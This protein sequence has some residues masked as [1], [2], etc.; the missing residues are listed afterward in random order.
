MS[1]IRK[2]DPFLLWYSQLIAESLGKND[3]AI[4]PIRGLGPEDQHTMLQLYLDGPKDK[5]YTFFRLSPSSSHFIKTSPTETELLN[6]NEA[7][8][9]TTLNSILD[10][11]SVVREIILEDLSAKTA[12]MISAHILIEVVLLGLLMEI[13]PFDQPAVE[14]VKMS[15]IKTKDT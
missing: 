4:T 3:S 9:H 15:S 11:N 6:T 7:C 1:Y 14:R 12:G 5:I 10:H 2:L 8:F 13:N